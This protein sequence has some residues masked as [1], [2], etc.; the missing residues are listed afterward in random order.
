MPIRPSNSEKLALLDNFEFENLIFI[1][2]SS[3]VLPKLL[4][5][6]LLGVKSLTQKNQS[7]WSR[8]FGLN[9]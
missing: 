6:V 5:R 9:K 2:H 3:V 4:D 7:S 1:F 8:L